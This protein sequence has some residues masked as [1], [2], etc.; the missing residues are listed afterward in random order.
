MADS[1][2]MDDIVRHK[3]QGERI[4]ASEAPGLMRTVREMAEKAGIDVPK[5]YMVSDKSFH[6]LPNAGATSRGNAILFNP[7]LFKTFGVSHTG[8]IGAEVRAIIGHEMSHL[9]H[10]HIETIARNGPMFL[11]PL[12]AICGLHYYEEAKRTQHLHG[13]LAAAINHHAAS[14]KAEIDQLGQDPEY[15]KHPLAGA[16]LDFAGRVTEAGRY[17]AIAVLGLAGGMMA[18]RHMANHY[19]FKADKLGAELASPA[20]MVQSLKRMVDE[21]K[22]IY[23]QGD[24]IS[25]NL[26]QQIMHETAYGHPS[27]QARF[28]RLNAM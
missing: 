5:L 18:S 7:A 3:W 21:S 2:F 23:K 16:Q 25:P 10:A 19:E 28:E 24:A 4:T 13:G 1:D 26:Y 6:N 14:D 17:A 27:Y 8:E 9:R 12:A 22:R 20:A 11:A 15:Q